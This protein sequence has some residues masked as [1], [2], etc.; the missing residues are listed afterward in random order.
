MTTG[1]T[2]RSLS[3]YETL[4][5]KLGEFRIVHALPNDEQLR[6]I[7][8]ATSPNEGESVL[9]APIGKIS[10]FNSNGKLIVRKDLQ[11][12]RESRMSWR[13][14]NDWH[15][16][17]H[18]GSQIRTIEI[19]PRDR[20]LPP[21]EYITALG[22]SNGLILCSRPL[23]LSTDSEESV[24]H[25]LNLFLELFGS[26]ELVTPNLETT[27]AVQIKR[28]HWKILPPGLYP[29]ARAKQELSEFIDVLPSEAKPVIE[30][31][32]RAI[33]NHSPD[34]IA[35]GLGG[36]KDYVVFG[37]TKT[38]TYVLE[39]PALG[40]ATYIFKNN[41]Q[42]LSHLTKRQILDGSLHE[43]RVIHNHRW[44]AGIRDAIGAKKAQV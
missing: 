22:S 11:K 12:V 23:S 15:G 9:P 2:L 16:N 34:F 35:T 28:L 18:S 31:R 39:S 7:G 24:I 44:R 43:A 25:L 13:T 36:F 17:P 30:E 10:E 3:A 8:F 38:E 29:F 14:W 41:W 37:F 6:E 5:H 27:S 33:T 20:V 26:L 42:E 19:Y 1:K 4:I 40:N 21:S 32:I